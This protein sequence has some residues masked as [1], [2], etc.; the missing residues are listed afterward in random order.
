MKL[1]VF[2]EACRSSFF[3]YRAEFY[4][5]WNIFLFGYAGL[6]IFSPLNCS[7]NHVSKS[8]KKLF[9]FLRQKLNQILNLVLMK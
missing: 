6:S 7:Q 3:E 9:F 1:C 2:F 8:L 5:F 4:Q